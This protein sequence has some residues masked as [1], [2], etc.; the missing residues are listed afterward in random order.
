MFLTVTL[1]TGLDRVLLV[2]E[3]LLGRPVEARK[4]I[5]CVGGKGLDASVALIGLGLPTIGLSFL[6]GRNGKLLEEIITAYGIIPETVWVEGE[7]RFSIVIAEAA[8]R[9]VSHIKIGQ[10]L[11]RPQHVQALLERFTARL[12]ETR[13]VILAGSIPLSASADLYLQ[14]TRLAHAAGVPVL[15]DSRGDPV[16]KALSHP[17]DILKQNWFEFNATFGFSTQPLEELHVAA[18]QVQAEHSLNALVITCGADGLLAVRPGESFR[19]FVPLQAAINAA[20]AGDAA[21]AALVWRL[22]EGDSWEQAL[23]WC[24]AVSAAAVLTEAT[25]EVKKNQ[26][27]SIYPQVEVTAA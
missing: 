14:L 26:A 24:G 1:N 20:G 11:V 13:Y 10:L 18:R 22:S 12:Q 23:K 16:L 5:V 8:H 15:I 4:E 17:P 9:R 2:D 6:A 19:V 3:L 27:E 21:S 7:T 25:G